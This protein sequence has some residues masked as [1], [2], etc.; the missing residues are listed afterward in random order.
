[1]HKMQ[2]CGLPKRRITRCNLIA[3][4]ATSDVV[5]RDITA[6]DSNQLW[7]TGITEHQTAG[8]AYISLRCP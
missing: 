4:P 6:T 5:K 3:V 8:R 2:L 1:M 7:V